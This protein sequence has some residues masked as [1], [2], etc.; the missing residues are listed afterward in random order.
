MIIVSQNSYA[1]NFLKNRILISFIL[2]FSTME[3]NIRWR[4][5]FSS[6]PVVNRERERKEVIFDT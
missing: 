4:D 6:L 2:C 1:L 5:V 3:K